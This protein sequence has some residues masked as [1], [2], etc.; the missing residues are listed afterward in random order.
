VGETTE[1]V[2]E[3]IPMMPAC[4]LGQ[5][6][7]ECRSSV[8]VLGPATEEGVQDEPLNVAQSVVKYPA[9]DQA[10]P[11][12]LQFVVINYFGWWQPAYL[13][14]DRERSQIGATYSVSMKIQ[15]FNSTKV[16]R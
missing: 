11:V 12:V 9:R 13:L 14:P 8:M 6:P 3:F 7:G 2:D 15:V 10:C 4:G 16:W 1:W 5:V